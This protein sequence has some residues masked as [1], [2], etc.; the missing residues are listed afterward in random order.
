MCE[1]FVSERDT[2]LR[3]SDLRLY[4]RTWFQTT[5]PQVRDMGLCPR[6]LH[7]KAKLCWPAYSSS[8]NLDEPGRRVRART[9]KIKID[10]A[11]ES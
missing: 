3:S 8:T 7:P 6:G 2:N 10:S 9:P 4:V 5:Y 1:G 11:G